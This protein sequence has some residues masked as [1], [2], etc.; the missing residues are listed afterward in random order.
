MAASSVGHEFWR[1]CCWVY[2]NVYFISPKLHNSH[3][4]NLG[5][6]ITSQEK[7]IIFILGWA[8]WHLALKSQLVI[9][10]FVLF[11]S[12]NYSTEL[13]R[14][15]INSHAFLLLLLMTPSLSTGCVPFFKSQMW[16]GRTWTCWRCSSTSCPRGPTS[17][18]TSLLSSR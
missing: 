18:T 11:L 13:M 7:Y 8:R 5:W 4:N 2:S 14:I 10:V 12:C 1:F 15:L 9:S 3:Q 6:Q 17:T 16:R